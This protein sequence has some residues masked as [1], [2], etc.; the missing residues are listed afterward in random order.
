MQFSEDT[1][2]GR[3]V[4]LLSLNAYDPFLLK[5]DSFVKDALNREFPSKTV[6]HNQSVWNT[7]MD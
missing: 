6:T 7:V 2:R 3:V 5:T 1:V 4:K